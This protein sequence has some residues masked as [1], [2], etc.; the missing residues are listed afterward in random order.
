MN[1]RVER[2]GKPQT[3]RRRFHSTSHRPTTRREFDEAFVLKEMVQDTFEESRIGSNR[4]HK[5]VPWLCGAENV[6]NHHAIDARGAACYHRDTPSLDRYQAQ[7]KWG[8]LSVHGDTRP[9]GVSGTDCWFCGVDRVGNPQTAVPKLP[10][11]CP[12]QGFELSSL[13]LLANAPGRTGT[14]SLRTP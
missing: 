14:V 11:R 7:P 5:R 4:Q 1:S 2:R 8:N 10:L 12:P 3:T 13:R 9:V 6:K